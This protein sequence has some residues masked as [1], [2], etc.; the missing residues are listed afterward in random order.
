MKTI[1]LARK[2]AVLNSTEEARS[3]YTLVIHQSKEPAEILEAALYNLQS[4]GDYKVSYTCFRDLYNQGY[5][6][7]EILPLMTEAFYQPNIKE[8]QKRYKQNCKL[9]KKYPYLFRKD[10]LPFE[11]LPVLFFPYDDHGF[12]PY[13]PDRQRFG[14][15]INFKNPVISRNFFKDLEKPILAGDVYSQ[16]EL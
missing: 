7:E 12:V 5:F 16:Y 6:Q 2:L 11:D 9:L 13:Y 15:Y 1:E 10:F 8:L 3:A 14:D 4:G